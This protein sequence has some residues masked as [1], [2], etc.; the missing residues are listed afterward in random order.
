M[1]C[2]FRLAVAAVVGLEAIASPYCVARADGDS[3]LRDAARAATRQATRYYAETV[4]SHGGYVYFYNAD[5]LSQRWG[6][7]AATVDM[8]FVQP[9]GTPTVGDAYL[10]AFAAAG[11]VE[12]LDAARATGQCLIDG[13]LQSGGWAQVIHFAPARR[14]G[15]YR[16]RAGGRM[17]NSSLDDGQTQAALQFLMR[18]DKA[19]E[20]DD[21]AVHEA[22]AY[23]LDALLAAQFANGGF[24]QVWTGPAPAQP[25]LPA[26]YPDYDWR[27]ERRV[28]D[29]WNYYTLND[30]LA[31]TVAE[32]L[33]VAHEIYGEGRH[34]AALRKLGDF[35]VLAQM[36]APQP[37]WCQQYNYQ[38]HPMWA[39]KF[40]PP[41]IA[42][43]ESQDAMRALLTIASYTG[44]ERYVEPIPAALEYFRTQC[45]LP[46]GKL[47]RFYELQTN[48]PLYMDGEYRLA[49]D[50]ESAPSHYGWQQTPRLESLGRACDAVA[51]GE[52][53]PRS[54]RRR[55]T[56]ADVQRII[57]ALDDDGRW[58]STYDG[59][60]LVGQPKFARGFRYLSSQVF[61]TNL[62][63]LARFVAGD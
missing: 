28:K 25:V 22:V 4:A 39:R 47:A 53:L 21:A 24:P 38:M 59:E 60:G 56:A 16:T 7:G 62:T 41:A 42:G 29:Y 5:D 17:N 57:A 31:G 36:P 54:P 58:V 37:A 40:E 45:M 11:E 8:A 19:L 15:A 52:S 10:E 13:Q 2:L 55:V 26:S 35:L 6:E 43:H 20:F 3:A 33:I 51:R 44:D 27:T 12:F 30:G 61:A 46:N 48:R 34:L 1:A 49:Y 32:T 18:L 9:P 50:A 14:M 63:K 23:G